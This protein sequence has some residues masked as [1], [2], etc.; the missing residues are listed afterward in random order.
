MKAS[1]LTVAAVVLALAM[2][3]GAASAAPHRAAKQS[4]RQLRAN[5][6]DNS[7]RIDINSLSMVVTNTGSFAWD[8]G[9]GGAGLEFPKGTGKTAVFAAGLWMGARVGSQTRVA[10]SEY[11]DD[12][13]PGNIVAGVAADP[14]LA[15]FK[16]Y[17]LNRAYAA[18]A[19]RDAALADYNAGAVPYGAPVVTVQ[20]DGSL[21]ILG[22]QMTWAVYNDLGKAPDRRNS[23]SSKLPLGVEIQQTTFAFDRQGPLGNTVFIR[24]RI[25]N[26]GGNTLNNMYISQWSD[27]DLGGFT[28]DL[29]GTDSTLGVGFV[30][31]ATN[32][33]EQYGNQSPCV[34]YDFLQGP[35][36]GSTRLKMTSFNKYINGTDPD[37]STKTYNYMQGLYADGTT[38]IDPTTG[39]PTFFQVSGDPVTGSGWLDSAPA[40]RRL[41][42]SSGPFTMAPGDMQEIVCGI[43]V[44]QSKNRLASIALMKFYDRTVQAAYDADFDLPAPPASPRV[45]ATPLPGSVLL[46]WETNAEQYNQAPYEFEGYNVYQGASVAGPWTRLATFDKVN[47][48]TV[49]LDDDFNED[50]GLILPTGKAFGTDAGIRYTMEI[51]NDVIR[52]GPLYNA[53]TYFFTVTAYAT[54]GLPPNPTVLESS[55]QPITIVPQARA[56]GVDPSSALVSDVVAEQRSLGPQPSTDVVTATVIDP[57]SVKNASYE[58]GFKPDGPG[59]VWY[60]A[61]TLG[62]AVDTVVNNWPNVSGD[63][64]YPIFDGIQVK[65]V[66]YPLGELARVTYDDT[67]GGNPAALVGVDVGLRFFDGG[68]DYAALLFG[69][70]V[71]EFSVVPNVMIRFSATETQKAYRYLRCDCDPRTYLLQDFVDVPWTVWDLDTGTQLNA[72][73]LENEPGTADDGIWDPPADG[74]GGRELIWPMTS[75]YTGVQDPYYSDPSRVDAL[76][77]EADFYYVAW[78]D[79]VS[80]GA[81]IDDGDKILFLTSIPSTA[82]DYFVFST[83]AANRMNVALAKGELANVKAVPNPYYSHS[84]YETTQF[85]RIVKI[86]HLPARATIRFF[87]LA[88]DLVR[89]LEKNDNTSIA[90]WNLR[91]DAGLPVGSGIY[92]FHV[93]APGVG[94]TTGKVA[95]F[96]EKE[97]LNNY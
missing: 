86:T 13:Q 43:V 38:V 91:T 11:S 72:G 22:D 88:G 36:V 51:S 66:S 60:V 78:P 79:R 29:V 35:L 26:R 89:T 46:S 21:D 27:P 3:A 20:T 37:D 44:A 87:N 5:V 65:V 83:T 73:W 14:N 19:D 39:L 32:N 45:A 9:T 62:S 30:Y 23:A 1:R 64:N 59:T 7:Q 18:A 81:P 8:K 63:E 67:T 93:D 74:L 49:V 80:A 70:T 41:M 25:Y 76:D 50:Q 15:V 48:V 52:G 77:G 71:P 16:T 54:G 4:P 40:D 10:V 47:G 92:I 6:V 57:D 42:L 58:V 31:N 96:M 94:T 17:K 75:A 69:S 53:Q 34:G 55:F 95:V 2:G 56:A 68:G 90:V 12:Y 28:D 24:Y 61:R 82:N 84:S 33:D 97:R 85:S